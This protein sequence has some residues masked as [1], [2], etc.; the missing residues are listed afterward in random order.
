MALVL[1]KVPLPGCPFRTPWTVLALGTEKKCELH[2]FLEELMR[3]SQRTFKRLTAILERASQGGPQFHNDQIC[4]RLKGT[5]GGSFLEF[6]CKVKGGHGARI[7]GFID[8]GRLIICTHGFSKKTN[9]T[10][11][12]EIEKLKKAYES[13]MQAKKNNEIVVIQEP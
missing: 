1:R 3:S 8:E 6:K 4:K 5:D 2:D 9:R 10:P 12:K 13:Y 7:L 11:A